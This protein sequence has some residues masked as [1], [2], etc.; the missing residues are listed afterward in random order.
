LPSLSEW[1]VPEDDAI[2]VA[3]LR[4]NVPAQFELYPVKE[5]IFATAEVVTRE[6]IGIGD[7][8]VVTGLFSYRHGKE[9]N[10]PIVRSGII[11][12]MPDELL[13]DLDWGAPYEAYVIELRS[14]SGVSGSPV[15]VCLTTGRAAGFSRKTRYYL[16]GL[17]RG[18]WDE[19]FE[20]PQEFGQEGGRVNTGVVIVS[21]VSDV[22][23]L[24]YLEEEVKARQRIMRAFMDQNPSF[25]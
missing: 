3:A 13:E 18:H 14:I 4:F 11:A 19:T 7:T 21:P 2:D 20:E 22:R 12:A 17:A 25:G 23:S 6:S 5:N 24:L 15:F 8:V 10:R 1:L 16:L 9:R